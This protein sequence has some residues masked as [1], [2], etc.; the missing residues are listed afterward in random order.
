MTRKKAKPAEG[1]RL[2]SSGKYQARYP[3]TAYVDGVKKIRQVSAGTHATIS[4]A[5][6]ARNQALAELRTG[7]WV[8][9]IG[10]RTTVCDWAGQWLVL[11]RV[12]NR[13]TT[14]FVRHHFI[15]YWGD[16]RL[17]E[18]TPLDVQRWVNGLV[19]DDLAPSTV[20]ALY[21]MFK[22]MLAKAV[23]YDLLVKS[24][25][26]TIDLPKAR[27]TKHVE[28]TVA[29]VATLEA[30]APAR[31]AAMIHLAAWTGLRWQEAAA[32]R[33]ASVDL[34]AGLVH[35]REAV[36]EADGRVGATKNGEDRWVP[37]GP[38]TVEVLRA[39]RRDFGST[40]LLFTGS[41]QHRLLNYSS[42]VQHT[43]RPLV[44]ACGI[45]ATGFHVLRHFYATQ[46]V[47]RGVDS[48]VLSDAMGHAS[49]GF[50]VSVYGWPREDR[51]GVV[52]A[53][54]EEAMRDV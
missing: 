19:D 46:M 37:I 9:P 17:G 27:K 53:A 34:E 47:K 39:H 12:P 40:D 1:V 30:R 35:V 49:A 2:L 42:F 29:D 50:T 41:Q 25:C 20:R 32:L 22:Q 8:D 33:W 24:P 21:A 43:W 26:R 36:K 48:K 14:S 51:H 16:R 4:D 5:K 23:D 7:N 6:D 44:S 52:V 18:I 45:E 28:I 3:V 54:I 10:P 13:R 11:R 31:Y 38:A 15:P